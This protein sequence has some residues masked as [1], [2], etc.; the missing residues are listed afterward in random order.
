MLQSAKKLLRNLYYSGF[1]YKCVYCNSNLR[2]LKPHGFNL[3]VLEKYDVIGGKRRENSKCPIC[4]SNDRERLLY[5]YYKEILAPT[6]NSNIKLLHIAPERNFSI[7]LKNNPL[8]EY[9]SGD[10]FERGYENSYVADFLDIC[11]T[12]LP[13]NQFDV[14]VCNHVLEH[15]INYQSA[16]KEI[17]RILK[18]NGRAILQVPIAR[19]LE[20][21]IEDTS[22]KTD[23]EREDSFGQ[24][25]HLR[26]FGKDYADILKQEGFQV[27]QYS[28]NQLCNNQVNKFALNPDEIIF[29]VIK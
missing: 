12:K 19:L 27:N 6:I 18:P 8:I 15:V 5:F 2:K 10:K 13:S 24:Y 7:V 14:I 28:S 22:L 21:T 29:E 3:P 25:D 17:L 11:D 26:L 1:N 4:G 23:K 16:L 20:K 9:V